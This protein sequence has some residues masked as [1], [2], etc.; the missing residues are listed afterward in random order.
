MSHP[1]FIASNAT[2]ATVIRLVTCRI[3]SHALIGVPSRFWPD[4]CG[5]LALA[6][7]LCSCGAGAREIRAVDGEL[8][9]VSGVWIPV[10]AEWC[11]DDMSLTSSPGHLAIG[12]PNPVVLAG[13]KI[14]LLVA[15]MMGSRIVRYVPGYYTLPARLAGI[16]ASGGRVLEFR[17]P[18]GMWVPVMIIG[19]GGDNVLVMA[20][21][22]RVR[23]RR[24][25]VAD[26]D[27][28]RYE[29]LRDPP[30]PFFE[31]GDFYATDQ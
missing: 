2:S 6:L 18:L 4:L 25:A 11:N 21:G 30:R 1:V 12:A 9:E 31:S 10:G 28:P 13:T 19:E 15:P 24:G 27:G 26:L 16:T 17:H 8:G 22:C 20:W 23:M 5:L 7:F 14:S 29:P 3:K